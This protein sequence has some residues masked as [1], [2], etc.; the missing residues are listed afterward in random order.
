MRASLMQGARGVDKLPLADGQD[1][2]PHDP[3]EQRPRCQAQHEDDP[4]KSRSE[5]RDHHQCQEEAGQ[6]LPD[7]AQTHQD[8]VDDPAAGTGHG[9]DDDPQR[10][11]DQADSQRD[12]H[13]RTD[14]V[15][16][17][18]EQVPTQIVGPD[19]M[20]AGRRTE[21]WTDRSKRVTRCEDVRQRGQRKDDGGERDADDRRRGARPRP[22]SSSPD[23][24]VARRDGRGP[25]RRPDPLT[26][27]GCGGRVVHR[28]DPSRCSR[29]SPSRR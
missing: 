9:S 24:E 23:A 20:D 19:Q 26:Q 16:H 11:G 4:I 6:H 17:A 28:S 13:G 2:G 10:K 14:P 8:V 15:D 29:R 5:E 25:R 3:G 27:S 18:A 12:E 1:L 21:G 22:R 7:L